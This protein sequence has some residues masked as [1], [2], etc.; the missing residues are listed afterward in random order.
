MNPCLTLLIQAYSNKNRTEIGMKKGLF[1]VLLVFIS[2]ICKWFPRAGAG[3]AA[4]AAQIMRHRNIVEIYLLAKQETIPNV[5]SRYK[6]THMYLYPIIYAHIA[7]GIYLVKGMR[8][9]RYSD[10]G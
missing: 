2:T 6:F 4:G 3:G 9:Q 8:V 10:R 7:R 1:H 5:N